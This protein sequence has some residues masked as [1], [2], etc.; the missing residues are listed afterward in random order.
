MEITANQCK[1]LREKTGVGMM[2]CKHALVE[3]HGDLEKA[4]VHLRERGLMTAAKKAGRVAADGT[5]TSYIHAGGKI[6]VLLELNCETDFVAKTDEFQ[7]LAHDVA[8]HIAASAPLWVRK[9]DVPAD[10]TARERGIFEAQMADQKKPPE[11]KEKII[12]GKL[13]KYF[14]ETC[15]LE[16]AFVKYPAK[17]I[18]Q[19]IAESVAKTG[20]NIQ[21]RRFAR[22]RIGEE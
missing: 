7:A 17:K 18:Q 11:I 15:L 4:I 9:E 3:T 22:Y 14:E 21:V 6:G 10:V 19:L 8:M 16:Q 2:E 13:Q 5:V 1:E 12:V 20:E